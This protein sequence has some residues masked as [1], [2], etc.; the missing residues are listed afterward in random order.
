[1]TENIEEILSSQGFYVSTTVGMSMWPMLKNRRDRIV[2]APVGGRKLRR[3]DVPLYRRPDGK[4]I[5]HRILR[6]KQDHFVIRGDNT[7]ALERVPKEW[8]I[9][10][11]TEFYRKGKHVK[12]DSLA[13]RCYAAV[14]HFLY[15][16]R[17][18]W[19]FLRRLAGKIKRTLFPKKKKNA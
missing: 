5:L 8:V 13:Y 17:L 3:W 2:I 6:V 12:T 7:Y 10:Y 4:Y 14:W 9:G 18:C 1:M 16:P 11:L 15:F 19:L